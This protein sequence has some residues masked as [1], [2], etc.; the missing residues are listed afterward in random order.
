VTEARTKQH[1]LPHADN[2]KTSSLLYI[3]TRAISW[4][5]SDRQFV[6]GDVAFIYPVVL[7]AW[8]TT[9]AAATTTNTVHTTA[10]MSSMWMTK[11]R[12]YNGDVDDTDVRRRWPM[13]ADRRHRSG[14]RSSGCGDRARHATD[15][16]DNRAVRYRAQEWLGISILMPGL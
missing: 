2:A 13:S 12:Y 1:T 9:A 14:T 6:A 8:T 7:N 10:L 3:C 15:W 16:P 4:W 11:T 5:C